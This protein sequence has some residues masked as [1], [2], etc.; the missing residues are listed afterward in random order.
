MP[1]H[2]T[3][4][5][6]M[7]KK[8]QKKF[9]VVLCRGNSLIYVDSW[10]NNIIGSE[11]KEHIKR[12]LKI[13]YNLLNPGGLLYIDLTH[14]KEFNQ[15]HYPIIEEFGEK[16]IDGNKIK[17]R[18]ELD[19]DYQKKIRIWK[20]VIWVN[21]QRFESSSQSYLLEHKELISLLK[22]VGFSQVKEAR[23]DGENVYNIFVAFK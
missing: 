23:I 10:D 16:I 2:L 9:D 6:D 19:H 18:W 21:E 5:L 7:D 1:N 15:L 11:T 13:F 22:E 8:I 17:L 12:S 3:N 4:W 20:S 14:R